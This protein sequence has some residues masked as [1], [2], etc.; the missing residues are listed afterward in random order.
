M[1]KR[2]TGYGARRAGEKRRIRLER[3]AQAHR[4]VS[5]QTKEKSRNDGFCFCTRAQYAPGADTPAPKPIQGLVGLLTA[6]FR[7]FRAGAPDPPSLRPITG[8]Q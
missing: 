5:A 7:R 6:T 2:A 8:L 3:P 1:K 4:G